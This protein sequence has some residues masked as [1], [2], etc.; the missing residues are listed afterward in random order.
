MAKALFHKNQRV[1]VKPVGTWALIERVIPHWVKDVDQPLKV[2]YDAGLGREFVASELVSEESMRQ[3]DRAHEDE[4]DFLY[5]NWR[6]NRAEARWQNGAANTSHPYPGTYPI[7]F[8]DEQDWGG[9]RVPGTEYD[10]DPARIE[11]QARMIVNAP[12]MV[13]IIK[14]IADFATDQAENCPAEILELSKRCSGVLRHV[15]DVTEE[16]EAELARSV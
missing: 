7:V 11:H 1:F 8:T 6:I 5:E 10:R 12:D 13:R 15:Y 4:D 16:L 9:W 14:E 2:T 3:A